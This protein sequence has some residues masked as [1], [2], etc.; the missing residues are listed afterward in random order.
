[1]QAMIFAAGLGTRLFP[2]TSDKPKAL[3]PFKDTTLLHYNLNFL[4]KNGITHFVINTHHFREKIEDYLYDHDNFGLD[5]SL[6]PEDI[7]LDTAGGLA[8]AARLFY[9]DSKPILVYNTDIITS[10]DIIKMAQHHIM[11]QNEV[12]LAVRNRV[13]SRQLIFDEDYRMC[14]WVN[15]KKGEKIQRPEPVKCAYPFAFSGIQLINP[16]MMFSI[17]K[18]RIYSMI[19]FYLENMDKHKIQAYLHDDDYWFDCGKAEDLERAEHFIRLTE[20]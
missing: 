18:N 12:T 4:A 2:I 16:E 7:L 8:N 11:E 20:K 9:P 19:T 13:S 5:I 15:H 10:L 14:G 6:S 3:A 1:M 17:E